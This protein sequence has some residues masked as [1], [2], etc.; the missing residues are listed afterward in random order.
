MVCEEEKPSW[1]DFYSG[2][3]SQS[4]SKP[5]TDMKS[6]SKIINQKT[7]EKN[8]KKLI[9]PSQ[10]GKIQ[11][12][13]NKKEK[14]KEIIKIN[15]NYIYFYMLFRFYFTYFPSSYIEYIILKYTKF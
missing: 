6:Y 4:W 9:K 15:K 3:E 10:W 2:E 5:L 13:E 11:E 1:V 7:K 8:K 14:Q 12:K